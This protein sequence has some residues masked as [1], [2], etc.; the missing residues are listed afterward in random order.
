MFAAHLNIGLLFAIALLI[1]FLLG[2]SAFQNWTVRKH[3]A[4]SIFVSKAAPIA[5]WLLG[6]LIVAYILFIAFR[7]QDQF[8]SA[9]R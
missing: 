8:T 7:L 9:M 5:R 4:G 3:H 1:I 2:L 6:L